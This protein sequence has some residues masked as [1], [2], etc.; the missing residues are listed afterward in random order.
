[1]GSVGSMESAI[2]QT[3]LLTGTGFT[4]FKA[5]LHGHGI[6]PITTPHLQQILLSWTR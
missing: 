5:V 3:N 1:M 2:H 6:T 4:T